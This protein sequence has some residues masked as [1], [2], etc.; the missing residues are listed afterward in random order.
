MES[1]NQ[2]E[3]QLAGRV[4]E[5]ALEELEQ[6]GAPL[7]LVDAAHIHRKGPADVVLLPKAAGLRTLGDVRPDAD[8]DARHVAIARRRLDHRPLFVRVVHHGAHALEDRPEHRQAD[9]RVALGGRDEDGARRGRTH[10]VVGVVVAIAEEQAVVVL[11]AV[12]G[13][14]VDQGGRRRTFGVEPVQLVAERV[15]LLEDAIGPAPEEPRIALAFHAKPP[16]RHAVD[17]FDPGRQ[18]V[19][20]RHVV[21]G[22]RRQDLDLGMLGEM[23]GDVAR[24]ELRAA[25]DRLSVALNDDRDLHC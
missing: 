11:A 23:F 7:V 5:V 15:R 13:E 14:V 25:V 17:R 12:L 2:H 20:P 22:A 3:R 8:H 4:V 16:H 9:R 6:L 18:L 10:A 1:A 24:V 21:G 19:A